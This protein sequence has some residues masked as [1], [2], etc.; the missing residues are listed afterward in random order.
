MI[1]P[2]SFRRTASLA[3]L[4]LALTGCGRSPVTR[5]YLLSPLM[6]V[7]DAP[8]TSVPAATFS[9]DTKTGPRVAVLTSIAAYLDRPQ[10]VVRDGNGVDVRLGDYHQW[11]EPLADGVTRLLCDRLSAA[12]APA[13]GLAFPLRAALPAEWRISVEITRLDGAPDR[14]ATLEAV[15]TLGPAQNT[16]EAAAA[17]GHFVSRIPVG[18]DMA[19][20][21]AAESILLI[22]L[23]ET[24]ATELKN[25]SRR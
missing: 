25:I 5:F 11:S 24:L 18:S 14:E 16:T 13:G 6:P 10:L 17:S 3:M 22:R 12:L 9:M 15:W 8:L 1:A 21:A 19:A 2:H 7:V 4:L 20:L 23:G